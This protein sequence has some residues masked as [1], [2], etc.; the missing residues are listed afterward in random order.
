MYLNSFISIYQILS[1]LVVSVVYWTIEVVVSTHTV[2][3]IIFFP[4]ELKRL[5]LS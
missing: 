4:F 1:G 3:G 2:I 5:A